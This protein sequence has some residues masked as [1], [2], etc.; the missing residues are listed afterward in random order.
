M[1]I[2]CTRRSLFQRLAAPIVCAAM[3]L[4]LTLV[5]TQV[6]AANVSV[7][8]NN[9]RAV[10]P[11]EGLGMGTAVYANQFGNSQLDERLNEAGVTTLRYS[12]GGYADVYH[13]SVHKDNPFGNSAD[14]G[15]WTADD[16]QTCSR[17]VRGFFFY[18]VR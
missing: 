12:G 7:D 8:V 18:R 10:L 4:A 15:R 6:D 17:Q 2:L 14:R 11:L 16:E 3:A 9:V 13:W 1:Q 5:A